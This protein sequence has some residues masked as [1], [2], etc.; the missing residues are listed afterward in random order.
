MQQV[1]VAAR[2]FGDYSRCRHAA[3]R[4]HF[5]DNNVP[6]ECHACDVCCARR[7]GIAGYGRPHTRDA[8][9]EAQKLVHLTSVLHGHGVTFV[10]LRNIALGR[11]LPT[12]S[13]SDRLF[14]ADAESQPEFGALKCLGQRAVD[15]LIQQLVQKQVLSLTRC[16]NNGPRNGKAKLAVQRLSAGRAMH[17][18]WRR[19]VPI[20]LEVCVAPGDTDDAGSADQLTQDLEQ[21][22]SEC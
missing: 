19:D 21:L 18:F 16:L 9:P 7:L 11:Q 17:R 22:M 14:A 10:K 1:D 20:T 2:F 5:G 12:N 3:L 4:T 6:K 8:F 15:K 13:V